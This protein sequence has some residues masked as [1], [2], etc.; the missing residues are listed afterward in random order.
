MAPSPPS[1]RNLKVFVNCPF[2][3][4]YLPLLQAIAFTVTACGYEIQLALQDVDGK[5]RLDKIVEMMSAS[6]LSIHDISRLP[7]GPG[8]S[9]RFNMPFECG[10]F[11]GLARS[12]SKKHANKQFLLMDSE[13]YRYQR[14]MSDLAGLDPKIH[15][16]TE[17]GV[18]DCVRHFLASDWR[19]LT[20]SSK[21]IPGGQRIQE[22]YRQFR[23]A[24]PA[25]AAAGDL[26]VDELKS[27]DY[28]KD[29]IDIMVAW[30][31]INA[32]TEHKA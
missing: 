29:L 7:K 22:A 8:D 18:S 21:V 11:I 14:N 23:A 1:P 2:D 27:F 13:Q 31:N 20:G 9:P 32:T 19:N 10:L 6:R 30:F 17:K 5:T 3:E 28:L 4:E 26:S 25:A 24:L 12:G 16:N 15:G